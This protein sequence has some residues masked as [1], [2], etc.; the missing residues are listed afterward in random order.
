MTEL[1]D[2]VKQIKDLNLYGKAH[3]KCCDANADGT[4]V[5]Q[6]GEDCDCP[7]IPKKAGG[8]MCMW[9]Y[10]V[11]WADLATQFSFLDARVE[12]GTMPQSIAISLGGFMAWMGMNKDF[13]E[14]DNHV[15][16]F[17][18]QLAKV[19]MMVAGSSAAIYSAY[20]T[21][22]AAVRAES[23]TSS[24]YVG[25]LF[26]D[27]GGEHLV[28]DLLGLFEMIWVFI[29]LLVAGDF[30]WAPIKLAFEFDRAFTRGLALGSIEQEESDYA[31]LL[32]GAIVSFGSWIAAY[33][34][35]ESA[36][37]MITFFDLKNT[38]DI[39]IYKGA[40]SRTEDP[41]W[42]KG[43]AFFVDIFN[44]GLELTAF[45]VVAY[46]IS[47]SSHLFAYVAMTGNQPELFY[48]W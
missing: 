23:D 26:V 13:H 39:E 32:F 14:F 3:G 34:L 20:P 47:T 41:D 11:S 21:I 43:T 6:V 22:D 28:G 36:G 15:D 30:A 48:Q 40:F 37:K 17:Y 27:Y 5:I 31:Y 1:F 29:Y 35:K 18:M 9:D 7:D 2:F 4:A 8:D 24:T 19:G 10:C 16:S 42:E 44:H 45:V 33:I 12:N 46:L 25:A 38:Q